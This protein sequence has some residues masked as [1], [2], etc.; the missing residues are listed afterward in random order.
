MVLKMR[1]F[2]KY[3]VVLTLA[4]S[5]P[6]NKIFAA[7][8]FSYTNL[9]TLLKKYVSGNK[10]NYKGL[11]KEKD[12]LF[13][14][15]AGLAKISPDS[16][17][18]LFPAKN[19]QLAYWINAYNACILEIIIKNYPVE[20]IKDINFIAVTVWLNKNVLG[21]EKISFKALEDD[22]IRDRFKD[23]RI[24]F[25]INCASA[26]CPPLLNEA[27]LP[28][29]LDKQLNESTKKFINDENNF[30]VDETNRLIYMNAIFD[31]YEDDYVDWLTD[32]K[33][34]SE[35]A[36]ILDYISIYYQ[37][38]VKQEWYKYDTEFLDY[39]WSLNE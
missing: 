25:A 7:E 16:D 17:P 14:F 18:D 30:R 32:T 37:G 8:N 3:I 27:Y 35:N 2:I 21:G 31:W 6:A 26:S 33:K 19:D 34:T 39:D 22:I 4:I 23:P 24:H 13:K 38:Q 12:T 9:D 15:T 28:E 20:S 10:V 5:A 11:L 29:I 36:V 1:L